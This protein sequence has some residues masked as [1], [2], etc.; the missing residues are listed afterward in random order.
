M[1]KL[2]ITI[3]PESAVLTPFHSDTLWG[4]ICWALRYIFDTGILSRFLE[5]YSS[6]APPLIISNAF[7]E[8]YLPFPTL[9]PATKNDLFKLSEDYFGRDQKISGVS[10]IK[11]IF[12]LPFLSKD[13]FKS[14]EGVPLSQTSLM[15]HLFENPTFCPE[16]AGYLHDPCRDKRNGNGLITCP[17]FDSTQKPCLSF[18]Q[19][20]V[21]FTPMSELTYH[22]RIDRYSGTA[23][24]QALFTTTD[25][26]WPQRPL[27][28]YCMID[29][30]LFT[31]S[32]LRECLDYIHATGYGKDKSSGKGSVT[33]RL[34]E[35]SPGD[36]PDQSNAFMCLSN[37]VPVK[38]DPTE[39]C[40][41]IMTKYGKLGGHYA[42]SSIIPGKEPIPY[43]YPL[44][45]FQQ[46]SI[47]KTVQNK[48]FYGKIVQE[49]HPSA[50]PVISHYGMAYPFHVKTGW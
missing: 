49:I 9:P 48:H 32:M 36:T 26:F 38:G 3:A 40:Y 6:K 18:D 31:E 30:E 5:S 23:Q 33:F 1:K 4:H 24:D 12:R 41:N 7:P 17:F 10:R 16:T 35:G 44:I 42:N 29:D 27:E 2:K 50:N 13:V 15:R 37:Y 21:R 46:G 45:M 20:T 25:T 14:F 22:V 39:G 8:G 43:K 19:K 34:E 47:F 28:A 11:R